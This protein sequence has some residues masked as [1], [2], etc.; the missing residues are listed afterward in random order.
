MNETIHAFFHSTGLPELLEPF[1]VSF[2]VVLPAELGDKTQILAFSLATRFRRPW[3]VLAGIVTAVTVNHLLTAFAGSWAGGLLPPR[4]L[5]AVVGSS[6]IAVGAWTLWGGDEEEH[7]K[8]SR[9]GAY[10]TTVI[11]FFLMEM[12]DK[13]QC[14]VLVLAANYHS[15][16][17]VAAGGITA[18]TAVNGIG[19]FLGDRVSRVLPP[20]ALRI[21]TASLFLV[22]G[23][24]ALLSILR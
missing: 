11:A 13:T 23:V 12:A 15:P 10:L 19:V 16:L 14:A 24:A 20:R 18:M 6:F 3:T 8:I 22:L 2:L 7:E 4:V 1:L 17:S 9:Y 21:G 5:A